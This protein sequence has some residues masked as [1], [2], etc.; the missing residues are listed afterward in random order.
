MLVFPRERNG[1]VVVVLSVGVVGEIEI[2]V[3]A[4]LVE[5]DAGIARGGAVVLKNAD[6]LH[7]DGA[8]GY[9]PCGIGLCGIVK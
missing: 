8:V 5:R 4:L 9:R 1:I 2:D 3:A 6:V 7:L